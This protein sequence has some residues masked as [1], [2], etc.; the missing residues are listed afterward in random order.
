[1]YGKGTLRPHLFTHSLVFAENLLR[2]QVLCQAV[3]INPWIKGSSVLRIHQEGQTPNQ[4]VRG[5]RAYPQV[6]MDHH[7]PWLTEQQ[8]KLYFTGA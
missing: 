4:K 2:K 3:G 6:G 7:L 5:N 1:M 8:G